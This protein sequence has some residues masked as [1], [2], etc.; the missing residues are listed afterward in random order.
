MIDLLPRPARQPRSRKAKNTNAPVRPSPPVW[1]LPTLDGCAPS[2]IRNDPRMPGLEL[3]YLRDPN[4]ATRGH[5]MPRFIPAFAVAHGEIMYAGKQANGYAI[6]I[7]HNNG[8]ATYFSNLE[9]VFALPRSVRP[10][11]RAEHVKAGDVLG[12]VGA[13]S[14]G[15]PRCLHF[16]LWKLDEESHFAPVDPTTEMRSWSLLPWSRQRL[17]PP[18]AAINKPLA[19]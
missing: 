7:N 1:P 2:V 6:L 14:E 9:H 17:T 12:Y 18:D 19:A 5:Q 11:S 10:R 8:W 13:P 3:A 4:D 15:E 16:E